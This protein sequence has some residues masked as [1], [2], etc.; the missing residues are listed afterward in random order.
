MEGFRSTLSPFF[1]REPFGDFLQSEE[2][3]KAFLMQNLII[4]SLVLRSFLNLPNKTL[5][6][7]SKLLEFWYNGF[8]KA[9]ISDS[10]S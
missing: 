9:R 10:G 8:P 5:K 6:M 2:Y 4:S 7:V 3:L 1:D